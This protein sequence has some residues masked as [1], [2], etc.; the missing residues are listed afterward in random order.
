M[1]AT[2]QQPH[3][4]TPNNQA[5]AHRM[6]GNLANDLVSAAGVLKSR[7]Y[8]GLC[9]G[10]EA[11]DDLLL[12]MQRLLDVHRT[13]FPPLPDYMDVDDE[14]YTLEGARRLD[15]WRAA[16]PSWNTHHHKK[17]SA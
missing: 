17:V 4:H 3:P 2:T 15:A 6:L 12:I 1:T 8:S 14:S 5:E 13:L 11:Q 10:P 16:F 9:Y 7:D